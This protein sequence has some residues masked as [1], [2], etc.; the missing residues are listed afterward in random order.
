M[1]EESQRPLKKDVYLSFCRK[2]EKERQ[3]SGSYRKKSCP[4]KGA[5]EFP[6]REANRQR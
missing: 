1:A 2:G 4:K 5:A 3:R 6:E